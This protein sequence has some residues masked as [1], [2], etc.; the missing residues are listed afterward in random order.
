[1]TS[2]PSKHKSG[3]KNFRDRI[4]D[5]IETMRSHP[6]AKSSILLSMAP[7]GRDSDDTVECVE[8]IDN[9][10]LSQ[11]LCCLMCLECATFMLIRVSSHRRIGK[12]HFLQSWLASYDCKE[13]R[14]TTSSQHAPGAV[15]ILQCRLRPRRQNS[16]DTG[17]QV[18]KAEDEFASYPS[19]SSSRD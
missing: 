13:R 3:K 15:V 9:V 18:C 10:G 11:Q 2:T 6:K 17:S 19:L 7:N 1:M 8:R 4:A 16:R 12:L 5:P 14:S